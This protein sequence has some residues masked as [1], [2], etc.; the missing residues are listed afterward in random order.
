M[1]GPLVSAS[2]AF[3]AKNSRIP[4]FAIEQS[5]RFNS[6]D[7]TY[8]Y[9][10]PSSAGNQRTWTW[11]VWLKRGSLG[12]EQNLFTPQYGGDGS[13]ENQLQFLADDTF[14]I[15]DSGG[16]WL[17]F[18]TTQVFRDP[19][20]WFHL[21]IAVDTTQATSTDRF[22]LYINGVQVTVFDQS[23]YPVQDRQLGW[24]SAVRHDIGRYAQG[25]SKY[26]N[27]YMAEF[28][29][30]DGTA[31]DHEDFGEFDD[32]GVWRPIEVSGLTYGT[33]GFYLKF[34]PSATNGIGHDHSGNGNNFTPTGFT[35]SGTGTDVMSDTPTNNF[36]TWNPIV[37]RTD[38]TYTWLGVLSE[39]NLKGTNSGVT[40]N[41][42]NFGTILLPS[43]DKYYWEC[44]ALANVSGEYRFG[45]VAASA[46][47]S[48]D[49]NTGL[50]YRSSGVVYLNGSPTTSES[51]WTTND[52]ISF[53]A[54]IDGNT[55]KTYK[56]GTLEGTYTS[57]FQSGK[58][59][60]AYFFCDESGSS[61]K[62]WILNAGQREFAYPPGTASATSYFNTVTYTGNGSTQ[63]ITGVGFQPDFVWIKKRDSTGNHMLT[64]VVRGPNTEIN[65]NTTAAETA[66]TNALT[67]FDTD[68]FSVGA[69]GAVNINNETLQAWCWKAG[70]ER[71]RSGPHPRTAATRR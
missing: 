25:A 69:D 66:N 7:S 6:A 57:F 23:L 28:H 47:G 70:G 8:L 4:T 64:D 43:S 48:P 36:M 39:G 49:S 59:Y 17:L 14:R 19:S 53:A 41:A 37:P 33:N 32:S 51:S 60:S 31:L 18:D 40:Y 62:Q 16:T 68:G 46:K 52:I 35:T 27:G 42:E 21:V 55:L 38:Q 9:R 54:D 71:R 29:M 15:Y 44:T 67:S 45:C 1:S 20:A 5:L 26:F 12:T 30:V 61:N 65:S 34:D 56:N 10:T 3:V 11:S 63:S 50:V 2:A 13:N 22:K 58:Q 24:N